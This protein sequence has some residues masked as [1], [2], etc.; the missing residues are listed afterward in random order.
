MK[1]VLAK[2]SKSAREGEERVVKRK[3]TPSEEDGPQ[4]GPNDAER[5][6]ITNSEEEWGEKE[7][8]GKKEYEREK[9]E[10]IHGKNVVSWEAKL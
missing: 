10:Q 6:K 9:G 3:T 7:P 2:G 8:P 4:V 5:Y 1:E